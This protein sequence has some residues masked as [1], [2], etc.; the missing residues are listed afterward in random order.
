MCNVFVQKHVYLVEM[1][2]IKVYFSL[3]YKTLGSSTFLNNKIN[4]IGKY[5]IKLK[6]L[7]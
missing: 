2:C 4:I 7:K 3:I 5:R 6:K 1:G